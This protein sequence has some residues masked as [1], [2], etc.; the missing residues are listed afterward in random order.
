MRPA[1]HIMPIVALL[2]FLL[3]ARQ[4]YP[5]TTP[6]NSHVIEDGFVIEEV[7]S[8][9]GGPTCME[10]VDETHLMMCDRDGGRIII[11]DS[12]DNFSSTTVVDNLY[13]PHGVHIS[14]ENLFISESGK[15]SR[16][17][18]SG[19]EFDNRVELVAGIDSGNH[20]TNAVSQ[21]PNGTLVW[22]SGSTCNICVEDDERNGALLWVNA[23]TGDHGI[24]ASGV[25]NSFDGVWVEGLGYIFTDNGRDWEGDHPFEEVNL[26]AQGQAYG[27]PDDEP[28]QPIPQGTVGP[29]ATWTP[30]TSLNGIDLRPTNSQLPGL[31]NNPQDGFTLYSSVYGSWNTI[32]PQGQEIVRIDVTPAQNNS[33]GSAGGMSGQGWDSKVTRFAVDLGTPLPLRFDANG[34]LYYATFGN[35]GSLYRITA[36]Q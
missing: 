13:H 33:D 11:L 15:L 30:H 7:A 27:W 23:T 32:L 26:L 31:E 14:E 16:Y 10:W 21:L 24:L 25:R 8:G 9:F 3:I 12:A 2:F 28:E 6:F 35:D 4:I 22:H 19:L 17:D 18:R 29:I 1:K 36:A 5:Y 20:Q 34:D